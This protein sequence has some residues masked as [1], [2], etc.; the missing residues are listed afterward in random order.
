VLVRRPPLSPARHLH[1]FFPKL[2]PRLLVDLSRRPLSLM[3]AILR[4]A[5]ISHKISVAHLRTMR[6]PTEGAELEAADAVLRIRRR[7]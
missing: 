6:R 3:Q 5:Q 7:A 4:L 2:Q 1:P